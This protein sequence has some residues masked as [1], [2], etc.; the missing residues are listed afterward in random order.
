MATA[1]A[2]YSNAMRLGQGFNSYTQNITIDSAVVF[3]PP[4]VVS[5]IPPPP[6][7]VDEIQR[8]IVT[9]SSQF[10][11]KLSDVVE[12]TNLSPSTSIKSGSIGN[13]GKGG[14]GFID[15]DK[16]KEADINYLI[17]VKAISQPSVPPTQEN[18]RFQ[19]IKGIT[20]D[21]FNRMFGDCFISGFL[22]GG[23][24]TALVSITIPDE[25]KAEEKGGVA[26]IKATARLA[27]ATL[28]GRQETDTAILAARKVL[29]EKTELTMN[30][31]WSGGGRLKEEDTQ[32]DIDSILR[33]AARFPDLVQK[34]P[35]RIAAVLSKYTTLR[36]FHEQCPNITPLDYDNVVLYHTYLLEA[37]MEYKYIVKQLNQMLEDTSAYEEVSDAKL[38]DLRDELKPISLILSELDDAKTYCR[39]QMLRIVKE[40][41]N[42]AYH[43]ELASSEDHIPPFMSSELFAALIP[44]RSLSPHKNHL[45]NKVR[46]STVK[47]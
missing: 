11:D 9:Y 23:E 28:T 39:N 34:C 25:V 38:D 33:V 8:Q 43:P 37:Y 26:K 46:R 32:W 15:C 27:L 29:S 22:E 4:K 10:V 36:S 45:T 41:D 19:R 5:T 18:M 17:Y 2:P 40:V 44:V 30:V 35:Q 3:D 7:P 21:V 20:Q 14:G 13:S 12:A 16:F 6:P 24:F 47:S 31:N 42:I 1:Y